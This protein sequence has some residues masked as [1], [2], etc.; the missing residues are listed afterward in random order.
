[1]IVLQFTHVN[2]TQNYTAYEE[3]KLF[4]TLKEAK[5]YLKE[6]YPYRRAPIYLDLEDGSTKKT[7]Y[8]YSHRDKYDDTRKTYIEDIWVCFYEQT[9]LYLN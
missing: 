6:N 9:P 5:A 8:V 2:R 1:M 4:K 3:E 7:G